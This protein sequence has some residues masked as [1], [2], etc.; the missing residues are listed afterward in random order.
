MQTFSL[1]LSVCLFFFFFAMVGGVQVCVDRTGQV[2]V[3]RAGKGV[4]FHFSTIHTYIKYTTK[5]SLLQEVQLKSELLKDLD[6]G[7]TKTKNMNQT[8]EVAGMVFK[9]R[10]P[11]KVAC[12]PLGI[13]FLKCY[14]YQR[15]CRLT[16][17]TYAAMLQ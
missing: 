1:F 16:Y 9:L 6:F 12:Q 17:A 2:C 3:R 10:L 5:C 4:Q 8:C 11:I 7:N 15:I 13:T 14:H